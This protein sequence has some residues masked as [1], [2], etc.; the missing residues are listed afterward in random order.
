MQ[1][2][3]GV[4]FSRQMNSLSRFH[5]SIHFYIH[6]NVNLHNYPQSTFRKV[7]KDSVTSNFI[8]KVE[9]D[10]YCELIV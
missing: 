5:F 1:K 10:N 2:Y 3:V 4:M 8:C 6:Q 7:F 9:T